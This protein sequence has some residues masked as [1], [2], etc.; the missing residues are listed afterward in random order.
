MSV[1]LRFKK[2]EITMRE[3]TWNNSLQEKL[4]K[5]VLLEGYLIQKEG[6]LC[7]IQ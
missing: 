5:D 1:K 3:S 6:L 7:K 2:T 4:L